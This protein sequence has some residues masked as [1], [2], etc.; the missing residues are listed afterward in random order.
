MQKSE[1]TENMIQREQIELAIFAMKND[2][3]GATLCEMRGDP[4][5]FDLELRFYAG[6]GEIV[7]IEEHENLDLMTAQ[8]LAAN[9][10]AEIGFGLQETWEYA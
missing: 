5:F 1:I 4:D 10:I 9:L 6:D 7:V 3:N 2:V 8:A